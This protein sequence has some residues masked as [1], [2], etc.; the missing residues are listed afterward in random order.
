MT[1]VFGCSTTRGLL[2]DRGRRRGLV[3][4]AGVAIVGMV[5]VFADDRALCDG[6]IIEVVECLGSSLVITIVVDT[7]PMAKGPPTGTFGRG[8]CHV[9]CGASR[10]IGLVEEGLRSR[11]LAT[12]GQ[13]R[14]LCVQQV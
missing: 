7:A 11:L 1:T 12:S 8:A 6:V 9:D 5:V 3:D 14:E 13:R 2:E 4:I 10:S